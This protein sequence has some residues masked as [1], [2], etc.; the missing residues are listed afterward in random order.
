MWRDLYSLKANTGNPSAHAFT[1]FIPSWYR[2]HTQPPCHWNVT[3]WHS[4][5]VM[6]SL[7]G[8]PI[9]MHTTV[10]V[11]LLTLSASTLNWL[12]GS[13][14]W[15]SKVHAM[16]PFPGTLVQ[17]HVEPARITIYY[18]NHKDWNVQSSAHEKWNWHNKIRMYIHYQADC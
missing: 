1:P 11:V 8:K 17:P 5:D 16:T 2:H 9:C 14:K 4:S 13:Q 18:Y 10:W 15:Q 12:P 7:V 6:L 3:S